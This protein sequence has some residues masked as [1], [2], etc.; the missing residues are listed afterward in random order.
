MAKELATTGAN[1]PESIFTAEQERTTTVM[2]FGGVETPAE[3]LQ[4]G[5]GLRLQIEAQQLSV[6]ALHKNN[7]SGAEWLAQ[8]GVSLVALAGMRG[9]AAEIAPTLLTGAQTFG[10]GATEALANRPCICCLNGVRL[11]FL[12]Y[13]EQSA[14]GFNG[15]ADILN[16]MA[17]DQVRMLISQC[18]HV[19]VLVRAGLD[20]GELPLPEWRARYRRFIDVGA[21]IVVDTGPAKGWE[22]YKNGSVFYGLGSPAGADALGL[23]LTLRRN[24]HLSYEVRALQNTAGTLDLSLN[25]A[26][27]GRIDAQNTL[28]SDNAAYESAVDAMCLRIYGESEL[29]QKHGLF[30][31]RLSSANDEERLYS[32]LKNESRRLMTIRAIRLKQA[33][34]QAKPENAK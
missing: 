11:G 5:E 28:L 25:D 32:L 34:E 33:A 10:A 4:F 22:T 29:T 23:F 21:S 30:G 20:E 8:A 18:D 13:G 3:K 2:I 14:V 27:R 26:F 31:T 7:A 12:S 1:T 19:I 15:K 17:F 24:G 9:D 16:L 6:G